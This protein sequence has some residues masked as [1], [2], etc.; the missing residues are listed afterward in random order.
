MKINFRLLVLLTTL[1]ANFVFAQESTDE[2]NSIIKLNKNEYKLGNL[3]LDI[4]ANK[5]TIPG[6]INMNEGI[7][8]VFACSPGGKLHESLIVANI[9]PYH[10]QVALLLLGINPTDINDVKITESLEK[11]GQIEIIVK[12]K[13]DDEETEMRAEKLIW[14]LSQGKPMQEVNWLF[15][16]SKTING[17]FVANDNKSLITTFNDPYTIIENPLSTRINDELYEVNKTLLPPIGTPVELVLNV[18]AGLQ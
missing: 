17:V 13:I 6:I 14:N 16:G 10:L 12:W 1:F 8:E 11:F 5:I 18:K 7:I 4:D 9:L 3:L 15:I 2:K